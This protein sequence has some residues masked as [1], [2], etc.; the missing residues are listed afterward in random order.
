MACIIN[1]NVVTFI[2]PIRSGKSRN[3]VYLCTTMFTDEDGFTYHSDEREFQYYTDVAD[4]VWKMLGKYSTF[5]V[6]ENGEFF[7]AE[8]WYTDTFIL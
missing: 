5:R 6:H 7:N 8:R 4:Y 2:T 1:T 3:D